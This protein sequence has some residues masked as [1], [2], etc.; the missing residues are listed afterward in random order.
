M[1]FG[2]DFHMITSFYSRRAHLTDIYK[3]IV[4]FASG[5]QTIVALIAQHQW[6]RIWLPVYFC[7]E[8]VDTIRQTGIELLFYPDYPGAYDQNIVSELPYKEGDVLLRMNYFGLR[9]R[10]SNQSLPIPVIEDHSHD[11]LGRWSLYSDADWCIAS[12]RKTL[13]TIEG[14]MV[15]SPKQYRLECMP[16]ATKENTQMAT[17]RYDAMLLKA[18]YLAGADIDKEVFRKL[19]IDSEERFG[20]L[21]LS[22]ICEQDKEYI[23]KFD[24]N[25]WYNQKRTNLKV[26][27]DMKL[28]GCRVLHAECNT[29][30]VFSLLLSFDDTEKRDVARKEFIKRQVYTSILWRIP[31]KR[32]KTAVEQSKSILSVH[33]DGRYSEQE[34]VMLKTILE[35]VINQ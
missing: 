13:P 24:I 16:Q 7:Y 26:F 33:V 15:W 18:E 11:L 34:M 29:C 9:T 3:D 23:Q 22:A 2:S 28:Q 19:Y 10:R 5:R 35:Q 21:P 20:H 8:V 14:G 4:F 6:K 17:L 1:E 30:N 32:Y 27:E 31:E 25:R 12:I